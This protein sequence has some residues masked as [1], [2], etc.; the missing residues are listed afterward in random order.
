MKETAQGARVS[1]QNSQQLAQRRTPAHSKG[2]T[3]ATQLATQI[4]ASPRVQS[5]AQLREQIH[6]SPRLSAQLHKTGGAGAGVFSLQVKPKEEKLQAKP[7]E[8]KIQG[9]PKDE[10]LQA[11][12]KEEK[13]QA[14]PKEERIQGKAKDELRQRRVADAA[15]SAS[16]SP[17]ATSTS[18][19]SGLPP[20]L[21]SG[22]ESL[23][24]IS[25]DH[26]QVHYN[27]DKPAQL[28]ALAYA[29]GS[30]IHV[31]PGQEQ[32]LPHEAWHVVQ[33]AQ[34][35]V[36]ATK[37]LKD[38][39]AINDDK[40][41]EHEADVKGRQ[42]IEAS[43]RRSSTGESIRTAL[44]PAALQRRSV[45]QG[46]F[47]GFGGGGWNLSNKALPGAMN[48]FPGGGN[49]VGGG[50]Q[51]GATARTIDIASTN[52]YKAPK[53][54]GGFNHFSMLFG[55]KILFQPGGK[56]KR[57]THLHV[58]NGKTYGP[59]TANNLTLG[60]T[61]DNNQHRAQVEDHIRTGLPGA[62]TATPY[63]AAWTA[64]PSNF[65][66]NNVAY[67]NNAALPQVP[68]SQKAAVGAKVKVGGIYKPYVYSAQQ[69]A[70]TKERRW[71]NYRVAP[72]YAG[73]LSPTIRTNMAKVYNA[74]YEDVLDNLDTNFI[75]PL[76]PG[77]RAARRAHL[78]NAQLAMNGAVTA[79]AFAGGV[80]ATLAAGSTAAKPHVKNAIGA[81]NMGG[82]NLTMG[83]ESANM[84]TFGLWALQAFP[85]ALVCDADLYKASFDVANA[86]YKRSEPQTNI[87]I[88]TN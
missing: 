65:V 50:Q 49:N 14:K 78:A 48:V 88:N 21:K 31:G 3:R 25:M 87:P 22:V 46:V 58:I 77:V 85:S 38:G 12:P 8:E 28:N 27:S 76:A 18:S 10:K 55:N 15:S 64:N 66:H 53:T 41:L 73:P 62:N 51:G 11:K 19:G 24:G 43:G 52:A 20:Q 9:K 56:P 75:A 84:L 59:G 45:V 67:W 40:G 33:Q 70:P 5:L 34:G 4:N 13:L 81:G 69:A 30:D 7:K 71:A 35:R 86:W 47:A 42:A 1:P 68:G 57:Y 54:L 79:G 44:T 6:Q 60:S 80:L 82:Y 26:V 17:E 29:Q 63:H 61:A 16:A 36:Q 72:N 32:H 2:A 74:R 23:S 37:Q 39:I 83:G